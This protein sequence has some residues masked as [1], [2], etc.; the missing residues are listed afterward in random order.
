M[1]S[2]VHVHCKNVVGFQS[3]AAPLHSR[4]YRWLQA[5]ATN[6]FI[7]IDQRLRSRWLEAGG[8]PFCCIPVKADTSKAPRC[9]T[10]FAYRE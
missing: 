9:L 6:F 3:H 8:L 10:L 1:A 5:P 4:K 2:V 7:Y